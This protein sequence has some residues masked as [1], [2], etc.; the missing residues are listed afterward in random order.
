MPY[1]LSDRA[2]N[3]SPSAW[4]ISTTYE[5]SLHNENWPHAAS[6]V[7]TPSNLTTQVASSDP[8]CSSTTPIR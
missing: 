6:L 7:A 4:R 3:N 2:R 5:L 1:R 8:A